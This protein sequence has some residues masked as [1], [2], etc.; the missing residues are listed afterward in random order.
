MRFET[1]GDGK[2]R[3]QTAPDA[4]AM[5]ALLLAYGFGFLSDRLA[6]YVREN[7]ARTF[8]SI[9]AIVFGLAAPVVISAVLLALAWVIFR[10]SSSGKFTAY[11]FII[12]GILGI[13]LF[14]FRFLPVS[15]KFL[16]G[17]A[18][19]L[20]APLAGIGFGSAF[21]LVSA[22]TLVLGIAG[23]ISRGR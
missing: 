1:C 10:R 2:G 9:P 11:I 13:L 22:Y 21:L 18:A 5:I 16:S 12:F 14:S 23:A 15:S 19:S 20:G 7:A 17:I 8:S 6:V 4:A 3:D